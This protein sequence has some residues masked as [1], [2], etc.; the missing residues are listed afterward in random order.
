[1]DRRIATLGSGS[2][3]WG[4]TPP[5]RARPRVA[6]A[7]VG[8]LVTNPY[9]PFGGRADCAYEASTS[10]CS[11]RHESVTADPTPG[12]EPSVAS[13]VFCVTAIMR[14]PGAISTT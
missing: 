8:W 1:M 7:G 3:T 14:A 6:E 9:G 4:Q 13:S 10:A 11:G 12:R 5:G 2:A